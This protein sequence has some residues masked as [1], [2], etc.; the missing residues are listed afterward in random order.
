M[1]KITHLHAR[2]ILDSRGNPTVEAEIRLDDGSFGRAEVPSGASTG[3]HEALELRDQEPRRY[4]GSGVLRAVTHINIE[5]KANVEGKEFDQKTLDETMIK[6]DGT[7][8]KA[9]LGANAILGVSLAFAKAKAVSQGGPLALYFAD[10]MGT[11]KSM[12]LPVPFINIING[13]AHAENST[14]VQEFMIAPVG[15]PNFREALR[16]SAETFHALKKILR[17]R[18]MNTNVG[19]EGGYAPSFSSNQTAIE[20]IL[21]AIREA[22]Y[23]P[24]KDIVLAIDAAANEF[25][26]NGHYELKSEFKSLTAGEMI[27]FYGEWIKKYPIA[28]LEDGLMEDDWEG[29]KH[30]TD[31]LGKQVQIVGDDLFVTSAKRLQYGI[32]QGAGNAILVKLNQIGTVT[33]TLDVMRVATK[34]NYRCMISHRSGETEDTTIADLAVGTGACQIKTGSTCRGERIAKYNQLLRLEEQ[35]GDHAPYA[36]TSILQRA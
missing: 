34:A 14:D 21:D 33:E 16:Y 29:F 25:Y 30:L 2:E 1:P 24:G 17:D 19:D 12:K 11:T 22:G 9:R 18:G 20:A 32:E 4:R 26:K 7:P 23:T 27:Q 15:A 13:G 8:N 3:S 10:L 35:L 6:L 36:G 28:S 5:L 31:E